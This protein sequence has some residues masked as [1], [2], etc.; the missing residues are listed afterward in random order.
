MEPLQYYQRT[1]GRKISDE[2]FSVQSPRGL[3]VLLTC[4]DDL[5]EFTVKQE[6]SQVAYGAGI[7][8]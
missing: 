2:I 4:G 8:T 6:D 7:L 1:D 5:S 3:I